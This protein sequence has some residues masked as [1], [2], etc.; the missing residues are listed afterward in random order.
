MQILLEVKSIRVLDYQLGIK[1]AD[2]IMLPLAVLAFD[3]GTHI[4]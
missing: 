1:T 3:H 2:Y 4:I